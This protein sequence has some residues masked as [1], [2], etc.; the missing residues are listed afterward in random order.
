MKAVLKEI[1]T[2]GPAGTNCEAAAKH[3]IETRNNGLGEVKLSK[4][5]EAALENVINRPGCALLGCIVY[6]DLHKIVFSN[7]DNLELTD[8]FLYPTFNMVI[9]SPDGTIRADDKVISHPAPAGL[10]KEYDVTF[11]TSNAAA[12][13]ECV[14]GRFN[15]C[16]TTQKSAEEHS[17]KIIKD[18][19]PVNMGFSIHT[20][21]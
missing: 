18:F 21:K 17:L 4:T 1:W 2:L 13:L 9:A 5:L 19:G 8:V 10:V 11:A 7:L 12:A 16:V 14:S 3:Y 20:P 6:P 15:A